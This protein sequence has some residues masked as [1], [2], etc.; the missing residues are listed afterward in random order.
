MPGATDFA[1]AL[2]AVL[3]KT[4]TGFSELQSC[5]RLSGGAS[6]ETW[7]LDITTSSGPLT[8]ALRRAVATVGSDISQDSIGINAEATLIQLA[9]KSAVPVPTIVYTLTA[10]DKLG[11]GMLMK[12]LEGSTRGPH[13][14]HKERY[15]DIRPGL[16]YRCGKILGQIHN[17]DTD[18]P[19][20]GQ[21]PSRSTRQCIEDSW[22]LYQSFN[23]PQPM[24]DYTARWLLDNI[25]Q[26]QQRTLLHGDFRNGNL[27]ICP[28]QGIS[29]VLDWE[30]ASI[31]DPIRDLGWLCV[32]SWRFGCP[33]L[34][35]GG[36]G[37]I[38]DLLA[39]YFES[40]GREVD[41]QHL[42]FWI[43]FGSFW[44]SITCLRMA[45]SYRD[46]PSLGLERAAIGRRSSEAQIDCADI[47]IPGFCPPPPSALTFSEQLPAATELL[48]SIRELIRNDISDTSPSHSQFLAKVSANSL[49]I[50]ER[51]L[52]LG[53]QFESREQLRLERLLGKKATLASLRQELVRA[54]RDHHIA[55][56][57][58]ALTE[59]LRLTVHGQLQ[60]D[61][62]GYARG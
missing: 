16:A 60:I 59:H 12:W 25:P 19:G 43:V 51:E 61:N 37:E 15:Q 2:E 22:R 47:I 14:V 54:I 28:Q 50:V 6:Q 18:T 10:Q 17:I 11:E 49:A 24:I 20:L 21:L 58:P 42:D 45:Y 57:E 34:P 4:I 3:L 52:Q 55:L 7:R 13:I 62:P 29:G 40:T 31:G 26:Q 30:L 39:G 23:S 53:Q 5:Q 56:N 35:V 46:N 33:S 9:A 27:M 32:N 38:K 36:F 1:P 44:W 48:A 8:L 41:Q